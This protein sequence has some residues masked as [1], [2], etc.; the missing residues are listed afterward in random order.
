MSPRVAFALILITLVAAGC[1]RTPPPLPG[2][3]RM[4]H[5][6]IPWEGAFPS[7]VVVD[8]AGRLWF[9]DR[10]THALAVFDPVT[11]RF[12]RYATP[13]PRSAPYGVVR[14][15][16]GTLWF[17]ESNAGRLGRMDPA[18]GAI[19]EVEVPGLERSGPML[20]AWSDSAVW[21]TSREP[22]GVYGRYEPP[23]GHTRIWRAPVEARVYGIAAT[24]AGAVWVGGYDGSQLM[25][26]DR[27]RDAVATLDLS[28][29][30]LATLPA[31]HLERLGP[32]VRERWAERRVGIVMRRIAAAPDGRIWVSGYGRGR[33]TGIDPASGETLHIRTVAQPSRPYGITVDALGR[34]WFSEQGNDLLVVYDPRTGRRSALPLPVPGGTV[35]SIAVDVERGRVWLPLS[36][37]GVIAVLELR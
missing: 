25:R 10:L 34:V 5:Y 24:P 16:D 29:P 15:P 4:L 8:E 35:R 27:G 36:D 13:T 9:T 19:E 30:Y 37:V 12:D 6:E 18:T 20:L 3:A 17:G 7:D 23:S 1:A 32:E 14:A 26:V 21:F 11:E 31:P 28:E 33:V 22:A 2:S